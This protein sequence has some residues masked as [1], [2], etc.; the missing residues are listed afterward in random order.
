MPSLPPTQYC[1]RAVPVAPVAAKETDERK[2]EGVKAVKNKALMSFGE[3]EEEEESAELPATKV[4][5]AVDLIV[6]KKPAGKK[7]SP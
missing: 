7:D 3:E 4:K 1:N 5:S 6:K 2:R